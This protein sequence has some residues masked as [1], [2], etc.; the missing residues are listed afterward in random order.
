MDFLS[1]RR[2]NLA[3]L[4]DIQV[5]AIAAEQ[6]RILVTHD[7]HTMPRHYATFLDR[8]RFSPG[9][10]LV[11]QRLAIAVIIEE[12]L[13]IWGSSDALEWENRIVEIPL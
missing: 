10:F 1:A 2:A 11:K 3:A 6:Q 4:S 9:V 5:L 12:L 8:N 13:L 7:F